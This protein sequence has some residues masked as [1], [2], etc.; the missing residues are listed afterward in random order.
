MIA[1]FRGLIQKSTE[2]ITL[3]HPVSYEYY[4][5][6]MLPYIIFLLAH[7]PRFNEEQPVFLGFQ[8]YVALVIRS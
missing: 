5:E 1:Y 4:P 8:K 7:H 3:D 6:Y 2:K